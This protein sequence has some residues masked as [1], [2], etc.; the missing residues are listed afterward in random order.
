M[1]FLGISIAVLAVW[2]VT[3]L[4][5]TEDGPFEVFEHCRS[6]LRRVSL[7]GL[8]DCFY[9][10]SMWVAAPVAL[11]LGSSWI[12]RLILW[13]AL[14]GAAIFLNRAAQPKPELPSY[15]EE[16]IREEKQKCFAAEMQKDNLLGI[17]RSIPA[18]YEFTILSC[19]PLY[20]VTR[21]ERG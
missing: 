6:W 16:P 21:D 19:A 3:H 20:S 1:N 4:L 18:P 9:C 14:S 12:E 7:A 8:A 10:L 15:F 5:Q 11:A 17:L 13:P 2:R